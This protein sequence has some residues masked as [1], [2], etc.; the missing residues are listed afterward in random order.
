MICKDLFDTMCYYMQGVNENR[1]MS[2]GLLK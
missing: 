2:K 1:N